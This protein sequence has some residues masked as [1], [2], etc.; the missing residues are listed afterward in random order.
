LDF[1]ISNQFH[2]LVCICFCSSVSIT[3]DL[4]S[5]KDRETEHGKFVNFK[6]FVI[7]TVSYTYSVYL[8][9]MFNSVNLHWKRFFMN[10]V[11]DFLQFLSA[12]SHPKK[13]IKR[14]LV[15]RYRCGVKICLTFPSQQFLQEILSLSAHIGFCSIVVQKW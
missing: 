11:T 12:V 6:L 2:Y 13:K 14:I 9:A 15:W 4:I 1:A 3:F 8:K 7:D 5:S 10:R